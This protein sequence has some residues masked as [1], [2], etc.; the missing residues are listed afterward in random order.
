MNDS[1]VIYDPATDSLYVKVR[2]EP[3]V[4]NEIDDGRDLALDL[5]AD[6]SVVG[7]DIQH[8]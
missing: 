4:D 1:L 3:S 5:G 8:A 6:G 2:P 7:Y